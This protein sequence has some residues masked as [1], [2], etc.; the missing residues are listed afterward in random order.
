MRKSKKTHYT[1]TYKAAQYVGTHPH[2]RNRIG[3][4]YWNTYQNSFVFRPNANGTDGTDG[5]T[6][7]YR[8]LKENL[9]DIEAADGDGAAGQQNEKRTQLE[10]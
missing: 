10:K 4:Y 8:V 2:I 6:D 3:M 7:W 1:A 9:I 5:K